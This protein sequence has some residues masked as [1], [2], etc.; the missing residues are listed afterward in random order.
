MASA[1]DGQ[2]PPAAA[3][4]EPEAKKKQ[5]GDLPIEIQKS[6]FQ[7]ALSSDL[8]ALALVSRHFH[9]IACA[10]LYRTFS[11]VFHDEDDPAFE[12]PIDGLA[13]G[14]DTIVTSEHDYGRYLKKIGLDSL[15]AGDV[16]EKSYGPYSYA[17]SCGKFLNTLLVLSMRKAKALETFY[18]NV[19]IELSRPLFKALHDIPTLQYLHVRMQPGRSLYLQPPPLPSSSTPTHDH[20][21][22]TPQSIFSTFGIS[23][24][25]PPP[26]VSKSRPAT[27]P[28]TPAAEPPTF[29]GFRSLTTLA[30]LDM[31]TLDY[32]PEITICIRQS[33]TTLKKL[34][35]SL[36]ETLAAKAR[37]PVVEDSDD[38]DQEMDEFGVTV[39]QQ[40]PALP[41]PNPAEGPQ[42]KEA[43]IRAERSNQEAVLG[44]IFGLDKPAPEVPKEGEKTNVQRGNGTELNEAQD[45][46]VVFLETMKM[47]ARRLL[48]A[49]ASMV[50][51]HARLDDQALK[52]IQEAAERFVA[53]N[54]KREAEKL[55]KASGI[56]ETGPVPESSGAQTKPVSTED[57]GGKGTA[58]D[59]EAMAAEIDAGGKGK[60]KEAGVEKEQGLGPEGEDKTTGENASALPSTDATKDGKGL[61]DLQTPN[62]SDH[63]PA[64]LDLDDIDIEHPDVVEVDDVE[65]QEMVEELAEVVNGLLEGEVVADGSDKPEERSKPSGDISESSAKPEKTQTVASPDE[66]AE[67]EPTMSGGLQG[68]VTEQSSKRDDAHGADAMKDYVRMTRKLGL[69]TLALYLI[70]IKPSVLS[71]SLDL[72]TLRRITLLNVGPQAGFWTLMAHTNKTSPLKLE[73]I[74]TDN[75]S[76][77]FVSLV[78]SLERLSELFMLERSSK[79]S[80][81]SFGGKTTVGIEE[82]RKQ[83]LKKH[84]KTLKKLMIKNEND[85]SWDVGVKTMKLLTKRGRNLT[86]MAI[87][88]GLRAFHLLLQYLP[89]LANL[90]A[91]H[92]INFRTDDTCT[93]V[94]RELRRFAIDNV[95]HHPHLKLEYI[96]LDRTVERLL[97]KPKEAESKRKRMAKAEAK[98][99]ALAASASSKADA[100]ATTNGTAGASA[101]SPPSTS[102]DKDQGKD[103]DGSSSSSDDDDDE[104]REQPLLKIET[105]DNVKFYDVYGVRIFRKDVMAGAL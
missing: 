47:A 80:L 103:S 97:R 59:A 91:L 83:I 79:A 61:F 63:A 17:E 82:I 35:L 89:G 81:E 26:Y 84:M 28:S 9:S 98:A 74:F 33:S 36:S 76:A 86:E 10:Q 72:T 30:V 29:S 78:N 49:A 55:A 66:E 57:D 95:A 7:H 85:Y 100:T 67:D 41:P 4:A 51:P 19:R 53:A 11:I 102:A 37:K 60:G 64:K 25:A 31:D 16:G 92:I 42:E 44:R 22:A 71:R 105:L 90:R 5:I 65:D 27:K 21:A 14:L 20:H 2:V 50:P 6:I 46:A 34:K 70:P 75:V 99:K 62:T 1:G 93:W 94:M 73:C 87:S 24:T 45:M 40:T 18:W 32:L 12:G 56:K 88:I 39:V 43:K 77:R 8:I 23:S 48:A 101:A 15:S 58:N 38:S 69:R 68:T 3:A 54:K 104:E 96:G 13:G 52:A